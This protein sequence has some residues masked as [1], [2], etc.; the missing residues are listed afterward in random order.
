[1]RTTVTLDPDVESLLRNRM[2]E[3]DLSF[4]EALNQALRQALAGTH[5]DRGQRYEVPTFR[6]GFRPEVALDKALALSDE[7]EDEEIIRKLS[8]RK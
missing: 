3:R 4:K 1:M 8:L 5:P 2:R 6:M 7:S